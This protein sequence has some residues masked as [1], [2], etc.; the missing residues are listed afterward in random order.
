MGTA[1]PIQLTSDEERTLRGWARSG[2]TE[3]RYARRAGYILAAAGGEPT[4]SIARR[5]GVRAGTVSKWRTRFA[6]QRLGGLADGPRS[7]APRQYGPAIERRILE[8]LDASP[9]AGHATWTPALVARA[10]GDV[11]EAYVW[12][13]LKRHGIQLQRRHS[14]CVSTDPEF[15]AKA[16][17]I[18]A[19]YLHPPDNAVVVAV[20]EKPGIQALERAQGWLRL[21]SGRALSGFQHDYKRHGTTT[22]FAA[23]NIATGQVKA[24]HYRRRR[25]REFLD[26]MNEVVADYPDEHEIHVI[27]DNLST[28]KPK[29]DRWLQRHPN[30]RLH[31]TPTHASWLNQVEIWFSILQRRALRGRSFTDPRQVRH[32]IDAFIAA[33]NPGAAPFEW[34]KQ[35]VHCVPLKARYAELC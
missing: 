17:D 8:Q 16:A 11:S 23:L 14:W 27:L 18:I 34:R 2:T 3:Q 25:R 32:A 5:F 10:V 12:R 33:Y 19:L 20:D 15:A 24:E 35:K 30:V 22:L 6:K 31:F 9:P 7:G 26:F 29:H 4:R 13:V 1:T 21:A 28:H